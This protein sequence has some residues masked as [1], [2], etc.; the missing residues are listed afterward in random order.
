MS[1]EPFRG[2]QIQA[3]IKGE[4]RGKDYSVNLDNRSVLHLSNSQALTAETLFG[5]S[6]IFIGNDLRVAPRV[7]NL[8]PLL[9]LSHHG[10]LVIHSQAA[11]L[12]QEQT[13]DLLQEFSYFDY[14]SK[15]LERL[16]NDKILIL[17]ASLNPILEKMSL[18]CI[19]PF[20]K[21][22]GEKLAKIFAREVAKLQTK[23]KSIVVIPHLQSQVYMNEDCEGILL[24]QYNQLLRFQLYQLKIVCLDETLI[25]LIYTNTTAL[26]MRSDWLILQ[27][28]GA[29]RV[30]ARNKATRA[31]N[32]IYKEIGGLA[33]P[34]LQA[35]G[36][37][38]TKLLRMNEK[39]R[40][41]LH[42]N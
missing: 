6:A 29:P 9:N 17:D 25:N 8:P 40:L 41:S 15:T 5:C 28:N 7:D 18:E 35:L 33:G 13:P 36:D 12:L 2:G 42:S 31:Y 11:E 27:Q 3:A 24:Q 38:L 23:A 34:G 14:I 19:S 32:P 30:R 21:E 37:Q 26:R 16:N 39:I 1:Q 10:Q 22:N 20:L 4:L